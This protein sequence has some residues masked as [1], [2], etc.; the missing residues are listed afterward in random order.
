MRIAM[1]GLGAV[2]SVFGV[3]LHKAYGDDFFAIA[4][5]KYFTRM[6][7]EGITVNDVNYKIKVEDGEA[8]AT[9]ADL[10]FVVVKNYGLDAAILDIKNHVG[11]NTV[12]VPLLNGI[13]ATP[14]LQAAFPEATVLYGIAMGID[15]FRAGNVV[16][17][18]TYGVIQFG[19]GKNVV[20]YEPAVQLVNEVLSKTPIPLEIPEEM[21]RTIW[22]KFMLNVGY[23][24]VTAAV[25]CM[26]YECT[27][28]A[29]YFTLVR[30]AMQEVVALAEAKGVDLHAE[31]RLATEEFMASFPKT[32]RT[33]MHQ[34]ILAGRMTEVDYFGGTVIE[35]SAEFGLVTPVNYVLQQIVKGKELQNAAK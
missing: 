34:D 17:F 25:D 27:T 2:G 8:P 32:A 1:I 18:T 4:A 26:I 35:M 23:N 9:P 11:A 7:N 10:I 28:V 6:K 16:D 31:D 22:K 30:G 33:S 24:Q 29:N 13:T 5:G 12:I 3:E 14:R 21:E 19:F 15:A 20:P